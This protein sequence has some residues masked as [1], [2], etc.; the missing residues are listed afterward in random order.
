MSDDASPEATSSHRYYLPMLEKLYLQ[1][2]K[3]TCISK[4]PC[5]KLTSTS[6][7]LKEID[8]SFN[9]VATVNDI[10]GLAHCKLLTKIELN[11]NPVN[12][13][14]SFSLL[15]RWMLELFPL[16]TTLSGQTP[17]KQQA[18]SRCDGTELF[19]EFMQDGLVHLHFLLRKH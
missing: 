6:A 5:N 16:L 19:E 13:T 11:D 9:L 2:N 10:S 17:A 8:L 1:D 3:I 14:V 15:S 18:Q 12:G 4:D 7:F